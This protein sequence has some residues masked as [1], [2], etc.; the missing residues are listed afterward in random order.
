MS[1]NMSVLVGTVG[2]GIIRSPDGGDTWQR[3][4]IPDGIHSDAFARCLAADPRQPERVWAGTDRGLLRND[5][6]GASWQPLDSPLSGQMVW[7]LFVDRRQ[8]GVMYAGSGTPG[9]A[10]LYFSQ[11]GGATWHEGRVDM[12][13]DCPAVG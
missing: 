3:L 10:R 13:E 2:Q 1:S 8:P 6:G 4:S 12:A 9:P 11:D 7:A 5:N